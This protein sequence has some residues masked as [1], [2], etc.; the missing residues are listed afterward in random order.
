M[1]S[2]VDWFAYAVWNSDGTLDRSLNLN[3]GDGVTESLGTPRSFEAPYWSGEHDNL[4]DEEDLEEDEDL[5]DDDV[6]E[7]DPDYIEVG[8]DPMDM[9][10]AAFEAL[11]GFSLMDN[12]ENAL[13][14]TTLVGFSVQPAL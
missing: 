9:A 7:D 14:M 8:F 1:H 11:F 13:S 5:E 10:G 3:T 4:D 2:I 12:D 6:P